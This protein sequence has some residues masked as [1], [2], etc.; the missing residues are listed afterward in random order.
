[1]EWRAQIAMSNVDPFGADRDD[2][3]AAVMTG[4]LM[5]APAGDKITDEDFKAIVDSL[6]DYLGRTK[7]DDFVDL[8]ALERMKEAN[9]RHR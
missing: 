7:Q 2:I 1:M 3:R 8:K 9:E 4:N 6:A 5:C